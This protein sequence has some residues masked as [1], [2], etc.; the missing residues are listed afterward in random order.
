MHT[1]GKGAR[2]SWRVKPLS[3]EWSDLLQC[4]T[5]TDP[6]CRAQLQQS[7]GEGGERGGKDIR[8]ACGNDVSEQFTSSGLQRPLRA[9]QLSGE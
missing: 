5:T 9:A 4:L 7:V 6:G 8:S 1:W 2:D 3:D